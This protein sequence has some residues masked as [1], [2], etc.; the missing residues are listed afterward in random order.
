MALVLENRVQ[1]TATPNTTVSFTLT[2]VVLG[3]QSFSAIG[4]GNT[5][6]YSAAD[7]AG[8]WEVGLGTYSSTG[9]TL[10]RTTIYDSSAAGSAVTFSGS[11]NVFVTYPSGKSI[12]LDASGNASPLGTVSSGAW[13]G[14]TVGVAY[15][16]TGVTAS[17]GAN[18]V[19]LR[20]TDQ[21]IQANAI[22]QSLAIVTAT[23][24][25]TTLTTASPHFQVLVG[26]G[27]HT[28]KMPDATA[29]FVGSSWVFDND[30]T[31]DLTVTDH[32]GTSIDVV[33]A[34]GY[35]T[36]FLEA[37]GTIAGTW[38]RY[39]MIPAQAN[40]GT[41]SLYLGGSTIVSGG[42]WQG[43]TIQPAYGGTGLTTF[44]GAN[45]ALY[46]TGSSTLTAGTLPV[47][48]GGTG[49]TSFA[50]GQLLIGNTT[51][52]TL[53][54]ATLTAGTNITID[55]APGSITINASG[56]GGG[57]SQVG[58]IFI[59]SSAPTTGTWLKTGAVY[60][61]ATYPDLAAELGDIADLG[62]MSPDP[63]AKFILEGTGVNTGKGV[64]INVCASNGTT[65]LVG[66]GGALRKTTDGVNWDPVRSS[67]PSSVNYTAV[68]YLNGNYLLGASGWIAYSATTDNF[69]FVGVAPQSVNGFA[70]GAGVYVAVLAGS[71]GS[72]IIYYSTNLHTWTPAQGVSYAGQTL[73]NI[74][75]ENGRFIAVGNG[76]VSYYSTNG[77]NWTFSFVTGQILTDIAFGAGLFVVVGSGN[78]VY[79]SP[80]GV[81]W[82]ARTATGVFHR[83]IYKNSLFVAIAASNIIC[84][85]SDGITW[86][87]RTTTFTGTN[88]LRGAAWNGTN[89]IAAGDNGLF[90]VGSSDGTTW[91]TSGDPYRSSY[92]DVTVF[93][94]RTIGI[95][96]PATV[97]LAGT[98]A[99]T[100][101]LGAWSYTLSGGNILPIAYNGTDTYLVVGSNSTILTASDAV[102]WTARQI[103]GNNTLGFSQARFLNGRWFVFGAP[104]LNANLWTSTDAVSWSAP[105]AS[106]SAIATMAYGASTY[107]AISTNGGGLT[108][109][110]G[111]TWTTRTTGF[112][113]N[114]WL[115]F[116]NSL[117]VAATSGSGIYTSPDGITWTQRL[118]GVN[119]YRIFYIN[120]LFIGIGAGGTIRTSTDGIA[121]TTRDLSG[122]G[123]TL[124]DLVWNGSLYV[125]VGQ[126]GMI[127]TSPNGTTWTVRQTFNGATSTSLIGV[128]W[129]GSKFIAQN[130]NG[131]VWESSDGATW[132]RIYQ[133]I[134]AASSMVQLGGRITTLSSNAI[135]TSIDGGASWEQASQ[136]S[137]AA[138]AV[139]RMYKLGGMYFAC[140]SN[141]FAYS[142]D[143]ITY[144]PVKTFAVGSGGPRAMAY[145]G[146][147]WVCV[148]QAN[149]TSWPNTFFRSTDGINWVRSGQIGGEPI[150]NN[151]PNGV[152]DLVYA[153]GKFIAIIQSQY[154]SNTTQ[155]GT[156]YTSTD[157]ITWT[158]VNVPAYFGMVFNAASVAA[159][160]GTTVLVP[161]AIRNVMWKSDDGGETWSV[162][163][164]T[165]VT[166]SVYSGGTWFLQGT[167]ALVSGVTTDLNYN[168]NYLPQNPPLFV[169]ANNGNYV[170]I[171]SAGVKTV[172]SS[173]GTSSVSVGYRTTGG[174]IIP[175]LTTAIPAPLVVRG[176]TG[177]FAFSSGRNESYYPYLTVEFPLY[178]Y[179]TATHFWVPPNTGG[180]GQAAYIYAGP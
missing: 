123:G 83:V 48:A 163:F 119:F 134:T 66:M 126:I 161:G 150:N 49:Q 11:V 58:E 70:Y 131:G 180:G 36:V 22:T 169:Y 60:S 45:N 179:N 23:G 158:K 18:S 7:A 93:A 167:A 54:K 124:Q 140:V 102:N 125:I 177:T 55:N 118:A 78:T 94:G 47:L 4:D 122:G 76:G 100:T 24:G 35:S 152:G 69:T 27:V 43:G 31:A 105:S 130:S 143:G 44:V 115:I 86:T 52:N 103:N 10:T 129:A 90:Y 173:E 79:S 84:T 13:Q 2:G 38:G 142:S 32:A 159:T 61:K 178:S 110:D 6:Y 117:F 136:S 34:G 144:T 135:I 160:D 114:S 46:S 156:V 104:G 77:I 116:A 157:G 80:D 19:V 33:A 99:L 174:A 106:G 153:N 172:G 26:T 147:V 68:S 82:T 50:N 113:V 170:G 39:G 67:N 120:S 30:S 128:V 132:L 88:N 149:G 164:A 17:S 8:N 72:P 62:D 168:V 57:S 89:F 9:P 96:N 97:V 87:Q 108:S 28:F 41:N 63:Q 162:Y 65:L 15:G 29:L 151:A 154:S 91:T 59:G 176:T 166:A 127:A 111:I 75:F 56:G 20:D 1:E 175:A 95:G 71:A 73:N 74:I 51:G 81:T 92:Y 112:A 16:G 109:P 155:T 40:W 14:S 42:T 137:Y 53:T 12:N 101:V 145:N 138:N 85:S 21:N 25:I 121:W 133:P 37:N 165:G 107:V 141:G 171:N 3:F 5:T 64:A 148:I 98:G 139:S 146:S